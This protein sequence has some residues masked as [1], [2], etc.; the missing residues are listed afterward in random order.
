MKKSYDDSL[1]RPEQNVL[2]QARCL[3]DSQISSI[4]EL[5]QEYRIL[6][7]QY[8]KLLKLS[9]KI[10]RI[11]DNQGRILHQHQS[12]MQNLLDNANQGFLT[13]G[14]DWKIG[15][16]FS[17]ECQR[18]F[19]KR[20][21]GLSILELLEENTNSDVS[22]W[23][24]IFSEVLSAPT[25]SAEKLFQNF[26]E[27]IKVGAFVIHIECKVIR[28]GPPQEE[29][30]LIMMIMTDVT[31]KLEAENEIRYLSYHDKLTGLYNRAY[32]EKTLE[33]WNS[34]TISS[35]GVIVIDMN[36]LKITNDVFGHEQGDLFLIK[37]ARILEQS[38]RRV[39]LVARWGGDEFIVLLPDADEAICLQI[40][41]RVE[42][43]CA[44][45]QGTVIRLSAA[46]GCATKK[47][48]PFKLNELFS[49]AENKMYGNKLETRHA[50][51]ASIIE[52]MEKQLYKNCF[53]NYGHHERL[54]RLC[55]AFAAF[56]GFDL[57]SNEM[58]PMLQ[59]VALH[60]I[61]KIAIQ[62]EIL[63]KS[64]A[65]TQTEW[66]LMKSHSEIG[67]RMAQSI[68]DPQLAEIILAVHERWD[69]QGYPHKLKGGQIPLLA[70]FFAIIDV[71][72]VLTHSRPYAPAFDLPNA[73]AEIEAGRGT[74][75][76]PELLD[77]FVL[78]MEKQ[79]SKNF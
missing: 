23:R 70:R 74:Q 63:G 61:G 22:R 10:F 7:E 66:E 51:R 71:F 47:E 37:L 25:E 21:D 42:E 28:Y 75:F 4:A 39:D 40:I 59:L 50:V 11:S 17:A 2:N 60:D 6:T 12:E 35:L 76:D 52:D 44:C 18:I 1:F 67:Y 56:C 34:A 77:Q 36:G 26:P 78:F 14:T 24:K 79:E 69:G 19:G 49:V 65:L 68:G 3:A 15:K 30:P 16:Q 73:L 53:V 32:V 20:I 29:Q 41:R 57:N 31:A 5:Q 33:D 48:A 54:Q 46:M 38:C 72:D 13:F 62:P 55:Q 9:R 27:M 64:A 45:E 43:R 58:K 8:E